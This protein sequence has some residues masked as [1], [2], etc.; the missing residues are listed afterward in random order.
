[1]S[2]FFLVFHVGTLTGVLSQILGGDEE[3]REQAI[4]YLCS[5]LKSSTESDMSKETEEYVLGECKKI[6]E[7]V[8]G[9]EFFSLMQVRNNSDFSHQS[10]HILVTHLTLKLGSKRALMC[11]GL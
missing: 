1:M 6:M 10:C 2:N 5:R 3:V 4:K 11:F 8:T 9:A 7:D